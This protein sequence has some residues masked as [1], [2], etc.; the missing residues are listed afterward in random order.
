MLWGSESISLLSWEP[1][2]V[3]TSIMSNNADHLIEFWSN[4]DAASKSTILIVCTTGSLE[5][6]L[7]G[8]WLSVQFIK[9][10][11]RDHNLALAA[12][13]TH[14]VVVIW[15]LIR[16]KSMLSISSLAVWEDT[17]SLISCEHIEEGFSTECS[18]PTRNTI[19]WKNIHPDNLV[20]NFDTTAINW[21]AKSMGS[22]R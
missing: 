5:N 8:G 17:G 12:A 13:H 18:I 10:G 6:S 16:S 9:E 1:I 21:W 19:W 7:L 3:Y 20:L 14:W 22:K 15:H 2:S 4:L 11:I